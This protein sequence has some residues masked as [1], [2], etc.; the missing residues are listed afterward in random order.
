MEKLELLQ[1]LNES[2]EL[3]FQQLKGYESIGDID[4]MI[5]FGQLKQI[6]EEIVE[7]LVELYNQK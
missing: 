2:A 5:C 4:A 1:S 7:L 3:L 6:Q